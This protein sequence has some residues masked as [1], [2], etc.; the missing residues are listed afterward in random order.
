MILSR[1]S[2][3]G[4]SRRSRTVCASETCPR[5]TPAVACGSMHQHCRQVSPESGDLTHEVLDH[6]PAIRPEYGLP[7]YP[8]FHTSRNICLAIHST[9]AL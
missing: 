1:S 6:G 2:K 3:V 7:W 5:L 8:H 4:D 9:S